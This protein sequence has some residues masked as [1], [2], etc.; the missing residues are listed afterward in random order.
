MAAIRYSMTQHTSIH[1]PAADQRDALPLYELARRPGK[2]P[3]YFRSTG[4]AGI[5][6]GEQW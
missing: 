4:F 2:Q 1:E 3:L 6:A 5:A